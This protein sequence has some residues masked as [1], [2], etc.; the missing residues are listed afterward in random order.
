[1]GSSRVREKIEVLQNTCGRHP[2]IL[3]PFNGG[4]EMEGLKRRQYLEVSSYA[5][6]TSVVF[7]QRNA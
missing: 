1:M 2:I 5:L 6:H 7:K 4:R 3:V